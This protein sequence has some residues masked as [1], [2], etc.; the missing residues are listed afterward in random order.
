MPTVVACVYMFGASF[1][2]CM[3]PI[4]GWVPKRPP[5]WRLRRRRRRLRRST[6]ATSTLNSYFSRQLRTQSVW[7]EVATPKFSLSLFFSLP[8]HTTHFRKKKSQFLPSHVL[9]NTKKG[10][11]L[12]LLLGEERKKFI[13]LSSTSPKKGP[14][15]FNK[16]PLFFSFFFWKEGNVY[17]RMIKEDPSTIVSTSSIHKTWMQPPFI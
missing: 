14:F 17:P 11:I 7:L 1:H 13:Y 12:C 3:P 6:L 15:V 10:R 4:G 5:M 2:F 8:H 16:S 9:Q